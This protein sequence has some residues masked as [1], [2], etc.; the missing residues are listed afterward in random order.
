M[1]ASVNGANTTQL[2]NSKQFVI[3]VLSG[4]EYGVDI[5]KVNNIIEPIT[6][7][8]VPKTPEYL[9][10]VINL[11]GEIIPIMDLRV[12]FNMP[13]SEATED[14]RY[15]IFKS[16]DIVVGFVVDKVD[17]VISFKDQAMETVTNITSD[18]TMDYILGVGKVDGRII[19]LLNLDK[20]VEMQ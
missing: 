14:T 19:T 11:R 10:G 15:I 12:K 6:I 8:R 13:I 18:L 2:E 1:E 9:K 17:E 16:D 3:F 7:T 5:Q 4:Q 20:L